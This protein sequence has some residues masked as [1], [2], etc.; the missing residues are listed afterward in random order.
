MTMRWRSRNSLVAV[1]RGSQSLRAAQLAFG[2]GGPRLLHWV[3]L[4][5][6][7]GPA[8]S[9]TLATVLDQFETRRT[10]FLVGGADADYCLLQVPDAL[11][12]QDAGGVADAIRWEVGRQLGWPVDEAELAAWPLP[13]PMGGGSNAMAIAARRSGILSAAES[14]EAQR[15]ECELAEPA[16]IALVR[17]CRGT[18]QCNAG[19]I[20]GVLDLGHTASRLYLAIDSTVVY[21]RPVRGSG[22]A[23]TDLIAREL[24]TEPAMA[25]H[26]KRKC[27]IGADPR[28]CRTWLGAA[29]PVSED[30]LPG[31]LLAVL[32]PSL[33][34]LASD[35]ERAFRF[36]ME[37]YPRRPAGSLVLAGGGARTPGLDAW[38]AGQLGVRVAV[39][40]AEGTLT[41]DPSHPLARP[42]AFAVMAGCIGMALAEGEA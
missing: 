2:D 20:W 33:G 17:A 36:V 11:W 7:P 42:A 27:G 14:L 34:E 15:T 8:D 38:L 10:G 25:E 35:V 13:A 39:A 19:E 31:V 12:S 26:Y 22:Q 29:E 28:G 41:V 6:R 24:H 16:A 23:W 40:A 3:N 30:A 32:K 9:A 4:E 1:D 5:G 18:A 21:V 37:Q